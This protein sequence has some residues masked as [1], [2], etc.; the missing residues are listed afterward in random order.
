MI[1]EE[2]LDHLFGMRP[3]DIQLLITN[4]EQRLNENLSLYKG[5]R[6]P[7]SSLGLPGLSA[8]SKPTY[9][10]PLSAPEG[11]E[12]KASKSQRLIRKK[13]GMYE[14]IGPTKQKAS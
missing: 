11:L 2:S 10:Q 8:P 14:A 6:M 7:E 5:D 1:G 13:Q 3:T 12:D 9:L 4:V